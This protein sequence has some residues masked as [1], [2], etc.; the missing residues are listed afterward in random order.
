MPAALPRQG[1]DSNVLLLLPSPVGTKTT[2]SFEHQASQCST[3]NS[4]PAPETLIDLYRSKESTNRIRNAMDDSAFD[5]S[6]LPP[7]QGNSG[8]SPSQYACAKQYLVFSSFWWS[9]L[10]TVHIRTSPVRKWCVRDRRDF[11]SRCFCLID[12]MSRTPRST[13]KHYADANSSV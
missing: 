10:K 13:S 11:I 3:T 5:S 1:V 9:N 8:G 4:S 7:E 12:K 2:T 6:G